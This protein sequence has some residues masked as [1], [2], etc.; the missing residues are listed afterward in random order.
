MGNLFFTAARVAPLTAPRVYHAGKRYNPL[1]N[2]EAYDR[3]AS[4]LS[5]DSLASWIKRD[6]KARLDFNKSLASNKVA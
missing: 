5:T 4:K 2:S 1:P 3:L 6:I